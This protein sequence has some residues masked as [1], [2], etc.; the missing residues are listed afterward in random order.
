[1]KRPNATVAL[2]LILMTIVVHSTE[3]A[4]WELPYPRLGTCTRK[5]TPI[6]RDIPYAEWK[7]AYHTTTQNILQA[8]YESRWETSAQNCTEPAAPA[9]LEQL[10][11]NLEPWKKGEHAPFTAADTPPVLLEHLRVYECALIERAVFLPMHIRDEEY[12]RRRGREANPLFFPQLMSLTFEQLQ[13]ILKELRTARPTLEQAL[14]LVAPLGSVNGLRRNLECIQRASLDIRNALALAAEATACLPRT[15]NPQDVL[16]DQ[17]E[18]SDGVDND[19]DGD[20]DLEDDACESL[21]TA[22]EG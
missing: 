6:F 20:V 7:T 5:A 22:S 8:L 21:S 15:W 17:T 4:A 14:T 10:A 19:Q 11:R 12:E 16:R 9:G 18:C 3:A 1:M 2:L 13:D